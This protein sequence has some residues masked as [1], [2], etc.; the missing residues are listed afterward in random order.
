MR[1]TRLS[2]YLGAA[3]FS[4]AIFTAV[5]MADTITLKSG[6]KLEGKV[7]SENGAQV[8]IEYHVSASITDSR[9]VAKADIEKI[10]KEL[11]DEQPY[12]AIKNLKLG[13]NSLP[14][15][16]YETLTKRLGAFL[17]QFP[18]STHAS[19]IKKNLE[20]IQAEQ[21]RVGNGELKFNERWLT[22]EEAQ[23]E[24]VQL[25]GQALLGAMRDQARR[26]DLVG[27]LNTFEQLEKTASG[28]RSYPD[29]VDQAKQI[30][31]SLKSSADQALATWKYQKAEREKGLQIAAPAER[32]EIAAANQRREQQ[33]EAQLAAA[34][35][36]GLV[37]SP[38]L[39]DNEKNLTGLATKAVEE[40]RKL[41]ALPVQKMRESLAKADAG[42]RQ[43]DQGD[44]EGA[45]ASL[46]EATALWAT[47]ELATRLASEATANKGK[48]VEAAK[49]TAAATPRTTPRPLDSDAPAEAPISGEAKPVF[50][51]TPVGI[52][53]S[54]LGIV[55][56]LTLVAAYRK[57]T[58]KANEILE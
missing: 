54:I 4:L 42:R 28:A 15:E 18:Q 5:A 39:A 34:T 50:F 29:A 32:A 55:F 14:A 23:K 10:D 36:S 3:A 52:V 16:S 13:P 12:Q 35:Q 44:Y 1:M 2:T 37:W 46:K 49:I 33:E 30:A 43:M 58:R 48:A 21:K 22:K 27:A 20:A 31:A 6:E 19:E 57:V 47:N 25:T 7:I 53:V 51:F 40:Q 45:E 8:T 56:V 17:T 11:P 9:T 26:G 24:R 38:F 41:A